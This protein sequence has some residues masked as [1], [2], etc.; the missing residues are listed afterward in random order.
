MTA[1]APLRKCPTCLTPVAE[2]RLGLRD[3][4]WLGDALPGKVA[5]MDVDF[6]LERNGRFLIIE[7][8]PR[9]GR[10]STGPLITFKAFKRLGADVWLVRGALDEDPENVTIETLGDDGKWESFGSITVDALKEAIAAW[11]EEAGRDDKR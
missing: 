3:Y 7:L 5:P 2:A 10:V 4:R 6:L 9:H 11:F 1:D 8:K